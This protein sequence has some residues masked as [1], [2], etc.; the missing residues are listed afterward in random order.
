[1]ERQIHIYTVKL[2]YAIVKDN[3]PQQVK[4]IMF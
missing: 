1:M 4:E 3:L 2:K